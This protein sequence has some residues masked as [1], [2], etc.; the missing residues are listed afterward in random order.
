MMKDDF[1]VEWAGGP[2]FKT[3]NKVGAPSFPDFGKGGNHEVRE[4]RLVIP[5]LRT[6]RRVGRPFPL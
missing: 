3:I 5:S 2:P 1:C 6:P 4:P